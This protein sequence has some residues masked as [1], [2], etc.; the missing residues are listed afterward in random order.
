MDNIPVDTKN[1][2]GIGDYVYICK[3]NVIHIAWPVQTF[4]II[5]HKYITR[6]K[7]C[8]RNVMKG[9]LKRL[10][11]RKQSEDVFPRL[12]VS[13]TMYCVLG[14]GMPLATHAQEHLQV[15][16]GG[17]VFMDSGLFFDSAVQDCGKVELTDVRLSAKAHS[18]CD[19]LLKVDVGFARNEVSLKDIFVQKKWNRNYLRL[20]HMLGLCSMEQ[21]GST[22]DCVFMAVADAA[23][24]FSMSRRI[25][26]TYIYAAPRFSGSAGVF[27]G[28]ELKSGEKEKMGYNM[29]FR[30]VYRPFFESDRVLHL[31]VGFLYRCPDQQT[32][33]IGRKVSLGSAGS[34][35]L[36]VSPLF[37]CTL[38]DVNH[39]LQMN[40]EALFQSATFFVQ[41]EYYKVRLD[42]P[43][44]SA[45][46]CQGM[47][48]QGGFLLNGQGF[49][50]DVTDALPLTPTQAGSW[51]VAGRLDWLD[52]PE[53]E[54]QGGRQCDV[55]LGINYY[56][57]KHL[58]F[59]L[60]G[61]TVWSNAPASTSRSTSA[62]QCRVQ[63]RF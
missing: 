48:V 62:V 42:V 27:A 30:G 2:H 49:G 4:Y 5:K 44:S 1:E 28:D 19:W 13:L 58:I 36:S 10:A 55:T 12:K 21:V 9:L 15:K 32:E 41:G 38:R 18:D 51:L 56:A 31:G 8:R 60:N 24:A 35:S 14:V 57:S 39:W 63:V 47:Y 22:N 43:S 50:Y 53:R 23:D 6:L 54:M 7:I 34:T 11:T 59:K 46:N 33:E 29:T 16:L 40:A 25:G 20:G 61:T 37:G 3:K 45:Y 17:R 52:L 26:A